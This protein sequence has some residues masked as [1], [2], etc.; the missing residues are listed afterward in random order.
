MRKDN[1]LLFTHEYPYGTGESFIENELDQHLK[2]FKTVKIVPLIKKGPPREVNKNILV[3]DLYENTSF[4]SFKILKRNF[5][6]FSQIIIKELYYSKSKFAFFRQL[7]VLKSILL[8]NFKRAELL[9]N[10]LDNENDLK[11]AVFYSFW[12]DDWATILS[13]LK[14]RNTIS[15]FISRVH[16]YDLYAKRWPNSII[17]FRNL[18]IKSVS[19]I[20]AVSKDGL[21]YLQNNFP[22]SKNKFYLSHLSIFDNGLAPFDD[23]TIFTIVSCSNLIPLKRVHLIAELLC[24]I[25]FKVKWVHFGSGEEEERIINIVKKMS[26]NI[27]VELKGWVANADIINYYKTN[28]VNVFI[29]LSE[30]EGGVPIVL[31]EAASFGIPLIGSIAGGT[32]EIINEKTGIPLPIDISTEQLVKV[33]NYFKNSDKNS[34]EFRKDVRVFWKNSFSLD[35]NYLQ[36]YNNITQ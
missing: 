21:L 18:Q 34:I 30:T 23:S 24:K 5:F 15:N 4:D 28:P 29:H 27:T 16:G 14:N 2:Y 13:I 25:N 7:P 35:T 26:D 6:T 19:K 9:K 10:Y 20:L 17:P 8:Q 32:E 31:Q 1:L 3:I 11:N 33:I 12:T 36:L 22:E